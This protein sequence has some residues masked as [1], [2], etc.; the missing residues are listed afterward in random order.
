MTRSAVLKNMEWGGSVRVQSVTLLSPATDRRAERRIWKWGSC[1]RYK[2]CPDHIFG[3]Y[4]WI[5]KC[6][7]TNVYQDK[8]MCHAKELGV[9][10]KGQGHSSRSNVLKSHV[11][12]SVLPLQ[13]VSGP[14]LR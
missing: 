10:L 1:V 6:F 7:G 8:T 5:L 14:Y 2:L 12:A 9:Y 4:R 11:C 3:S 13:I